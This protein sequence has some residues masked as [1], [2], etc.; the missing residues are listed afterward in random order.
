[1]SGEFKILV[2]KFGPFEKIVS[3]FWEQFAAKTGCNLKLDAVPLDLP[4]LHSA[5]LAGDFDAAH[6]NTDWL[7]QCWQ[8]KCLQDLTPYIGKEPP[9]DYPGGW[10]NAL[11]K[12]QTFHD[13]V[14]GVPFHDG[15]ECLIYRKDLFESPKEKEDFRMLTGRELK[16]PETWEDFMVVAEFFNRPEE[17][18]WGTLF[19]LFPDGHNNI[20][21]FALQVLSRGGVLEKNGR[22][23][24]HTPE[25]REAMAFYRKLVQ[26]PVLHPKSRELESIGACWT[27]ARG[28]VAMMVNWFGFAA[29]CET[30]EGSRVKGRVD[31]CAVP[32]AGDFMSPVSLNV[33]YTWSVS[34]KS[35]N[36]QTA[37]DF[38]RHCVTREND[39]LLPFMGAIGC[40]KSTWTDAEVNAV[41]PY[42]NRMEE[43]HRYASTLPRTPRWHGVSQVM[44]RLVMEV[45]G[46]EKPIEGILKDAQARSDVLIGEN[47]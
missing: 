9:Q 11:L 39:K 27:F 21:D 37:Y 38:I 26:S 25:A 32:H 46:T 36:K 12:L 18:L 29:M 14:A 40:R 2:R 45:V 24:L 41:I 22:V 30:V 5:I 42:Y 28:E 19:A 4:D 44:D 47:G 13:G 10:D 6:V 16:P 3:L 23:M 43:I 15:P 20:F 35:R 8:E 17:N 7:A 31:I 34:A 33:Y 1:M